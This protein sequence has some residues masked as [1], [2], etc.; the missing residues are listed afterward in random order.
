VK[1]LEDQGRGEAE[2]RGARLYAVP[3]LRAVAGGLQEVSIV[4]VVFPVAGAGREDPRRTEG[5]LV[6]EDENEHVE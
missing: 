6:S 1:V 2:V 3:G 4:P 5:K